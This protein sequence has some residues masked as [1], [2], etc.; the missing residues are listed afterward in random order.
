MKDTFSPYEVI[1]VAIPGSIVVLSLALLYWW[2]HKGDYSQLMGVGD[3]GLFVVLSFVSGHLVHALGNIIESAFWRCFG[4]WPTNQVL[5]ATQTIL[6]SDQR[7][8]LKDKAH[9]GY[10]IDLDSV[11]EQEWW[12][13]TREIDTRL[14]SQGEDTKIASHNRTYSL[15]RGLSAAFLIVAVLLAFGTPEQASTA[16]IPFVLYGLSLARMYRYGIHYARELL[17]KYVAKLGF[18]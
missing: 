15:M 10:S 13:V 7:A 16:W 12:H 6:S 4:G 18:R 17:L 11:T 1:G 8:R 3:L 5:K 9:R 2:P 14:R